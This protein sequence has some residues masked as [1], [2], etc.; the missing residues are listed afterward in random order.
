MAL[1]F[2]Y[3]SHDRWV[4]AESLDGSEARVNLVA[5]K[6]GKDGFV[7]ES[8][9]THKPRWGETWSKSVGYGYAS[10]P[11]SSKRLSEVSYPEIAGARRVVSYAYEGGG[12]EWAKAD[13]MLGRVTRL[14]STLSGATER[15]SYTYTSCRNS[16]L[17]R[18]A[19]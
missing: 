19:P 12:A 16:T 15:V 8:T 1:S 9:Q 13:W 3:D 17:P 7:L 10:G 5:R 2:E 11:G 6:F 18:V 4:A 14:D